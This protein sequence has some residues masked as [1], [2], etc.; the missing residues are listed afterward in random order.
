M[1][2]GPLAGQ[3]IQSPPQG[4]PVASQ[5][6]EAPVEFICPMDPGVRA[7][8]P[9]RCPRCGMT[10]VPGIPEI[11]EYP[12]SVEMRPRSPRAG[13]R[14]QLIFSVRHPKTGSRV[15]GFE[16]VHEKLYHL[17]IVSQDLEFFLHD[18]PRSS[19]AG[20]FRF[21]ALLPKPGMYR[22]LSD[23]YP[24]NGTPQLIANTVIVPGGPIQPGSILRSAHDQPPTVRQ[25]ENMKVFLTMEPAQPIAGM[26]TLL[27]F[28]LDPASGL[29]QYLGA[30]GHMLA[31]SED[32]IDMIHNHPFLADG[33]PQ[34]QFNIIFP[35]PMVYRVWVQFQR[36]GVVNTARFD[37]QVT[38][39]K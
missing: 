4:S 21:D 27:F 30:W 10:L 2:L 7:G 33:G 17:F 23:F 25:A 5:A 18:H 11:S 24:R 34:V 3:Q 32:L 6:T 16:R 39:L 22:L 9:G 35:R 12:V 1:S 31:A 13:E 38:E 37:I 14:V 29:E 20:V 26:K 28:R 19:R 8:N 36:Q 15:T